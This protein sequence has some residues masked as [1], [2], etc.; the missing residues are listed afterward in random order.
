MN[1]TI[2]LVTGGAGFLGGNV[3]RTLIKRGDH[4]RTLALPNDPAARY[5]PD[6]AEVFFGDITN[7]RKKYTKNRHWKK[8]SATP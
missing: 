3:C 5:I 8:C 1:N 7:I 2:Y 6:G 4:V